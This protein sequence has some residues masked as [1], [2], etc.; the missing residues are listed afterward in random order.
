MA[1]PTNEFENRRQKLDA[2]AASGEV[3]YKDRFEVTHDL[4]AVRLLEDG[5]SDI[6]V[7]GRIVGLRKMGKMTFGH[8]ADI[9]GR[10]QFLMK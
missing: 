10:F 7:A 9:D 6:A 4:E 2:V 1:A 5:T 8:I 3:V